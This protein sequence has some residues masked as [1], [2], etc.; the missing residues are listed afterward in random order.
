MRVLSVAFPFAPVSPDAAGGAEQVLSLVERAL[1]AR[2]HES[3]V[4]ASPDSCTA[5]QLL[6]LDVSGERAQ[7]YARLRERLVAARE[8]LRPDVIHLHGLD[9]SE[10][11]P[12]ESATPLLA[13]LHMARA[14]YP[15]S[16][17]S[18]ARRDLTLQCVSETQKRTVGD[19]VCI[20][21]GVALED[22]A[23]ARRRGG[24][25]AILG[26]VCPE[27]G[28]DLAIEA[29]R[30]ADVPLLMAG[31][32]F[33]YAAHEAYYAR[34]IAPALDARV[35]FLGPVGRRARRRLLRSARC[36]LVPSLCEET[37]SLVAMEALA[38]GTPV[39]AFAR[40]ALSE[41]IEHGRTGF[42]VRDTHEMA[43][44]IHAV[45]TLDPAVC[46]ET[47]CARF[48]RERMVDAYL[49]TYDRLAH[50]AH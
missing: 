49:A 26:R 23:P 11:L 29:A 44:A 12:P 10:Y 9:F 36:L 25:A 3:F 38:S 32:V 48:S 47:A 40:G 33:P 22:F 37:S 39:V 8:R 31:R 28:F 6:P 50:A 16:V 24:F 35:R 41:V 4:L 19:A 34:A 15:E 1:V 45:D 30:E 43:Q 5:G 17:F 20:P 42:L 14:L 2:G 7:V 27:K 18:S 13:T 21:N 46:R